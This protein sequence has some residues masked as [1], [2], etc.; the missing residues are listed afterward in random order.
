M[1]TTP[2]TASTALNA[3]A[4]SYVKLVLSIG[5]HDNDYVD[6][7]FGPPSWR[8][9]VRKAARSLEELR[10]SGEQLMQLLGNIDTTS[11]EE[12]LRLRHQYLRQQCRSA[13]SRIE[14]LRGRKFS[15]D[16][17][18]QA[19]YDARPPRHTE[20]FFRR[21]LSELDTLIPGT[22]TVA[23]RMDRFRGNFIIRRDKLDS[24]FQIAIEE[25]RRRTRQAIDL[26]SQ[27][28]FTL[29]YVTNKSWSGYNWYKGDSIS[30]I[31]INTDL[32]I[33]I[34]RAIDLAAHEGY[35]GH[36]VYNSLLDLRLARER[37]WPEFTVYALFSPQSL[38]AEGT[39]N[40]GIEVAFPGAQRID[41]ERDTLFPA[42]GLDSAE[43]AH[44]YAVHKLTTT[45]NYAHNEA[46][47]GYL[48]G[49][50][51]RRHAEEWLVTYALM[52]PERARQRIRF[53]ETYRSYVINYNL[54]QDLVRR[55]IESRGGT[56]DR[57]EDRWREF[58]V[59]ISSPRLPSGLQIV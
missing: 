6:A 41:F 43:A 35:P 53:I 12:I 8:D 16:E 40:F 27:E 24:V 21:I 58:R 26:P 55:Y 31:Q 42:A 32:P 4:E 7:Y 46:A 30:L 28:R 11:E 38:I 19:L 47:R 56:A 59:L 23:E 25:C 39:A 34:D 14:M 18:A 48:D 1:A 20:D 5:E 36:H 10:A 57:P 51:D 13:L 49:A 44:Y 17:E 29:E 54:G 33:Y 45:L 3:A 15:F 52:S 50:M 9:E 22:G 2:S 37:G